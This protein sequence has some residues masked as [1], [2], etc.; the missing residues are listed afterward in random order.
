M[1]KHCSPLETRG[2]MPL[3]T[4]DD[5]GADDLAGAIQAVTELRTASTAFETR[6]AAQ[7][8]EILA[9]LD[10]EEVRSQRP[11]GRGGNQDEPAETR[12]LNLF[13]RGGPGSLNE[14]ERRALNLGTGSAGGYAVAAEYS[15]TLLE[16]LTEFSPIRSVASVMSIGTT[17]VYIP[18]VE[19]A[20]AGGWVSETG[21]RPEAQP[22]F[23]Q[24]NI[25]TFEHAVI[26]PVSLQLL[27]DNQVNLEAFLTR[28]IGQ[29]FGKAEATAFM[30]GN[31]DGKPTG[32]L[33]SPENYEQVD[34]L[35]DGSDIIA[36]IIDLHYA[37]AGTYA[38]RASWFMN[39]RTMGV[40]RAAADNTTKGTL[41]SDSLANGTPPMLLGRPVFDSPDMD[42]LNLSGSASPTIESF[43]VAFGD[44]ASSYQIVDR[45]GV[46]IMRDD[47]TGADNGIVKIRAR[48]RVGGKPTLTES[49]VLLKGI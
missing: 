28:H 42:D 25:D 32:L 12:A 43:P 14:I 29:Q 19:T 23:G 16:K 38:A 8:A 48:R 20:L 24:L 2:A 34:A 40:I 21:A 9:R 44:F 11:G 47:F 41:W 10:D 30:V 15:R 33:N 5:G 27:E 36:K 37:L 46:G 18:T 39:R 49:M 4:R 26:V 17:E 31:G 35:Q 22:V 13:L 1:S 7:I 3:E 45:V 6:I